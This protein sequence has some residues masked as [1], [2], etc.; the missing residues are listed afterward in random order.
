MC[1]EFYFNL[2]IL[3]CFCLFGAL[4]LKIWWLSGFLILEFCG[5]GFVG[6][7]NLRFFLNLRLLGLCSGN[8]ILILEFCLVGVLNLRLWWL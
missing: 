8:F 6:V 3:C 4:N 7:I 2:E 5:F 1:W